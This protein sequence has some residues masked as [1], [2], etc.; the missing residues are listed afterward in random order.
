ML[1]GPCLSADF[2]GIKPGESCAQIK[3][4]EIAR[5][6]VVY[7]GEVDVPHDLAFSGTEFEREVVIAYSCP[8]G[9]F[10]RGSLIFPIETTDVATA[11]FMSVHDLLGQSFGVPIFD[12]SGWTEEKYQNMGVKHPRGSYMTSW[13]KDGIAV[14]INTMQFPSYGPDRWRVYAMFRKHYE[15]ERSNKSLERTREE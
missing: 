8:E 1:S 11:T 14:T 15:R 6:S 4:R 9:L 13:R 2:R 10:D 3:E 12:N 5:G 7:S